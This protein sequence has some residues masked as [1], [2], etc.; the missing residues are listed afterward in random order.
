[1]IDFVLHFDKHLAQFVAAYGVWVY[2]LLFGIIFAETGLVV[3]PFLP[4]DSLLFAAGALAAAGGG[5][6]AW[7]LFA[8]LATA[9]FTGN[10]VNYAVGRSIG[11]RIFTSTDE[12]SRLGRMMNRAYLDRAHAFF[13]QYGGKAIILGRFV[14]I[15]RTFVPFVAGAAQMTAASF[16]L[17][18]AIGAVAWVGLC[19]L[20]GVA[21]G[22]VPIIKNNFSLVTLGIVFVSILPVLIEYVR[23][24]SGTPVDSPTHRR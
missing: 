7:V 12:T 22:N 5:L 19:L 1:V 18:N 13:D 21:F 11:P 6:N 16:V 20:A 17:Y 2:G 10:A 24:R 15:V 9:A 3:T 4:G 23:H 14:P 8:L